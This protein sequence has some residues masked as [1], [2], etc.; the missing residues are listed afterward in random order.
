MVA[1]VVLSASLASWA[2]APA[3]PRL[4]LNTANPQADV[5]SWEDTEEPFYVE[6]VPGLEG[7]LIWMPLLDIGE[8]TGGTRRVVAPEQ[9][10][11]RFFRWMM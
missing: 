9:A 11:T 3:T 10:G 2:D 1:A 4:N 6:E 8:A 7:P 5:L